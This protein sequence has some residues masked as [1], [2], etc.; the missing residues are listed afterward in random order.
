M[1]CR[2][3]I[4]R[5][6]AIRKAYWE[7]QVVGLRNWTQEN[8]G[9]KADAQKEEDRR[10][11]ACTRIGNRGTCHAHAGGGDPDASDWYVYEFDYDQTK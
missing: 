11:D 8:I 1:P 6:P 2:V 4:T 7:D 5:Y 3:G 10:Q 9:S